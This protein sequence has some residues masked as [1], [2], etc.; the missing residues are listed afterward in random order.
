[1]VSGSEIRAGA[2]VGVHT[3]QGHAIEVVSSREAVA[4]E[5]FTAAVR[6]AV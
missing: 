1:V 4:D 6:T 2:S 5:P 3:E